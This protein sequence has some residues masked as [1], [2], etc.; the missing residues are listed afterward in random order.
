MKFKRVSE[1]MKIPLV[2]TR[3]WGRAAAWWHQFK[4]TRSRLGKP[5]VT[6]WEKTKKHLSATFLP[7][8]YKRLMYQ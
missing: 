4:L 1:E 3:L 8:N 2:A 7:Y 5:K 6:T